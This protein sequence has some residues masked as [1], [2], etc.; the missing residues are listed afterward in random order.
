MITLC[1][2]IMTHTKASTGDDHPHVT[3][4]KPR[5]QGVMTMMTRLTL[6]R[7]QDILMSYRALNE[8]KQR[9]DAGTDRVAMELHGVRAQVLPKSPAGKP[10]YDQKSPARSSCVDQKSPTQEACWAYYLLLLIMAR[11]S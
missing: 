4:T 6:R 9:T 11:Y 10:Y 2:L 1:S 8:E 3:H 5:A 7:R